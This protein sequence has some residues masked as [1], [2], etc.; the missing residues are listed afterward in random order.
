MKKFQKILSLALILISISL[1][2]VGCNSRTTYY[3]LEATS[4]FFLYGSV[5]GSGT[6]AEDEEVAIYAV[7]KE[8]YKFVKWDDNNTDNPRVV[9]MDGHKYYSATFEQVEAEPKHALLESVKIGIGR[10][11]SNNWD[12]LITT[13][14]WY[15]DVN[16]YQYGSAGSTET[17]MNGSNGYALNGCR[18]TFSSSNG[19][20]YVNNTFELNT[21]IKS[22]IDFRIKLNINGTAQN[23]ISLQLNSINNKIIF[24]ERE[25]ELVI[26]YDYP[27]Y[28]V[29]EVTFIYCVI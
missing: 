9:K 22:V 19:V 23:M 11:F 6:Y 14:N 7:P 27:N 12:G 2:F 25:N 3:R 4:S 1:I 24:N 18:S 13:N 17:L 26:Y 21:D 15:V 5:Y 20:A 28:G 29:I 16:G 10:G 8:G